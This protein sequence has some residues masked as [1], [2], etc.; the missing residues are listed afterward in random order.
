[1]RL[2]SLLFVP[3]DRPERFAKAAASG[4]DAIILDLEDSVA[5]ANKQAA[6][7]HIADYLAKERSGVTLVRVNPLDG[8]M[9]AADIAAIAA[10][11]PDAIMLPKAEG[12]PS[13]A[14]LDTIL[15]SEAPSG[16][17]LP[18]ILPIATET[19]AAIFTV[20]SYREVRDRLLGLTWGAEDLPAAIGAAT[21][22]E[23]D[24]SYTDPYRVARSLTLFAA[25]AAGAAAIDTVFPAIKDTDGLAAYAARARRDGFTG[26]MAIHPAQVE[27]INAA[28]TPS[29]EEVA[30]AQAIVDAFAANPG[31]GVLQVDG[32]MVDAPHLKQ[33]QHI[34]ALAD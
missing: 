2:R 22:R 31:V 7:D 26:M 13:I 4:A 21:S 19:P 14:Q 10:A 1:M 5:P 30:R 6:R 12:A 32:K 9:T 3:G 34:L 23:A 18:P 24:G 11:R 15:R 29:T 25:H 8:H 28:F 27:P 16:A 33:A 20:G 17:S